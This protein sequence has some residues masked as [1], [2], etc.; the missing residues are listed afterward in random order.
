MAAIVCVNRF[1]PYIEGL[2]F[3]IITD[4]SSLRWLMSQKD[5]SGRLARWSLK[6]QRY[7]FSIEHRKGALNIVPDTL[8]RMDVDEISLKDLPVDVDLSSHDFNNTEYE[9]L[10]KTV[11]ENRDSL[12]DICLKDGFVYKRVKFREG[13]QD[14]EESLWRLWIP[15]SLVETVLKANHCSQTVCHGGYTKTLS[16]IRRKYF[17]PTMTRDVKNFVTGCDKCKIMKSSNQILKPLMGRAFISTRPFERLYCDFLGPYPASKAKN[18]IIFIC[19]DHF[20]KYLFLKAF[21]AATSA[22][23]IQY[24]QTEIFPSYGVPR[25]LHSDNGRQFVS[26]DM[27]EFLAL[28][29]IT[30]IKTGFY[31]PQ[32]N[33]SERANREI[34]TKLRCFLE[35]HKDHTD[36]DKYIP[37]ILTI[38]R[39]DYHSAIQCT[40]Y[41]ATFGQNMCQHGSCYKI[42]DNLGLNSGEDSNILIRSDKLFKIR[43]KIRTNLDIAHEKASKGY[44]LRSRPRAFQVGQTVYRKN[45]VLSNLAKSVNSKFLPKFLK[46]RVRKRIGNNIY[47]LEDFKGSLL[48]RYHAT[49]IK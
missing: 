39:S 1:R 6:L 11:S 49:D 28:Y 48:G 13:A 15:Q 10:R 26:K 14:E 46:C 3:K 43:E 5:L 12:P 4:H 17:W 16:R 9:E 47:E 29:D 2:P 7:D 18:T 36:W 41:Y 33:A 35:D 23:V 38:L 42:L 44:N 19:L 20:T 25:Y 30:H 8:S 24:F 34:I 37:Q 21:R 31:A 22:N 27:Q 45:H 32:S 40:P